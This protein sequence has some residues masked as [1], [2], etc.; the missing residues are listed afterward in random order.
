MAKMSE[1]SLCICELRTAAQSLN[2]VADSLTALFSGDGGTAETPAPKTEAKPE[3]KP[4]KLETVR[5]ALAEKSRAGHTAEVRELLKK[6]GA[7]KLSE[8]DPSHYVDLLKEAEGLG[9]G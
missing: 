4:I 2:A 8:I 1:L 6:H 3:P 7:A 9:N 5:A